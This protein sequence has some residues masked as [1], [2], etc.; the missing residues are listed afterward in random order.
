MSDL[1]TR[2]LAGWDR[3]WHAPVDPRMTAFFR[4]GFGLIVALVFLGQYP[5]VEL[6]WGDE[7]LCPPELANQFRARGSW[8]LLFAIPSD[9]LWVCW[10]LAITH[11][12]LIAAGVWHRLNAAL[13][14]VW[15]ISFQNRCT[16]INDGEDTVMKLFCFLLIFID[17]SRVWAVT[18]R[19][20]DAPEQSG[21]ALRLLQIQTVFVFGVAGM[22][23]WPGASWWNGE[24]MF[25]VAHLD[26]YAGR[27]PYL[28]E[29][30]QAAPWLSWPMSTG[31][32]FFEFVIPIIVW[33]RK[34]RVLAVAVAIFFHLALESMSHLYAFEWLMILGWLTFLPWPKRPE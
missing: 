25:W 26:D 31:T 4:I 34:L 28:P 16:F 21:F 7:G 8:S 1:A 5:F 33:V 32:L 11:A 24:A 22:E 20:A 10:G 30:M 18:K 14:F 6:W 27:F 15:L 12:L 29:I 2:A 13:L 9:Y 23:K 19:P 17:A 3:F